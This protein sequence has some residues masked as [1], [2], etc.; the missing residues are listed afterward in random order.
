MM[1]SWI[2]NIVK[3]LDIL[4]SAKDQFAPGEAF[5]IIYDGDGKPTLAP[6]A[7]GDLLRSRVWLRFGPFYG[8]R[9]VH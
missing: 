9:I 3:G 7:G 5:K 8:R 6:K 4:K 1:N 2:Q